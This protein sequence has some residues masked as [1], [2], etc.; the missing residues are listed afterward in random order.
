MFYEPVIGAAISIREITISWKH[1]GMRSTDQSNETA[2]RDVGGK[3][4]E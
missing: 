4:R 3:A 2:F 1:R